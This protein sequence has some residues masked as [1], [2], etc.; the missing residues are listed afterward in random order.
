MTAAPRRIVDGGA[1]LAGLRAG[2]SRRSEGVDGTLTV[3]GAEEHLPYNRPPLSKE[4]LA[5]TVE[6]TDIGLT[7]VAELDA[8]WR[9]G[10]AATGLDLDERAVSLADGSRVPFDGLVIATGAHARPLPTAG[11]PAPGVHLLRTL[12]DCV[13]LG[14]ALRDAQR[15]AVV[16]AGFIGCEVA[17]TASRLGC[18]VTMIDVAVAP[19]APRVG[20]LV[21]EWAAGFHAANGIRLALGVGVEALEGDARLTAV[22]L[23]DGTRVEADLAVVGL[24][25]VP[26]TDWLAG[27]GVPLANGVV[28]DAS[29][30]VAGVPG[31]VA[32]GDVASWPHAPA[33]THLR[34]EHWS[35]A[36]E[37]GMWAARTLLHGEQAGP[38]QT[39][40]SFWSDQ[41]GVRIQSIG[42]PALATDAVLA[43][44]STQ[45]DGFLV[46]YARDEQVVGA[47]S[48]GL[49]PRRIGRLRRTVQGAARVDDALA[50]AAG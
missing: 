40:P 34:V 45:E 10:A 47:L 13:A 26:N 35:N 2:E 30:A 12:D 37:Q 6:Q 28:C 41:H 22:R 3:I 31:V 21:G 29:L 8:D 50:H 1:A 5:G 38:F 32:A 27:S 11:A 16:G 46:L 23:A 39:L 9:L 42:L 36:V 18:E 15:V 20:P 49:P 48:V 43:E 24:G 44:G 7:G 14:E 25:S 33:G 4:L 19:M 17:A